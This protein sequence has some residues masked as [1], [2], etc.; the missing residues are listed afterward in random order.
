M[1][2]MHAM[3]CGAVQGGLVVYESRALQAARGHAGGRGCGAVVC[4][5][6]WWGGVGTV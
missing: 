6:W 1:R 3:S 5:W 2:H 4:V